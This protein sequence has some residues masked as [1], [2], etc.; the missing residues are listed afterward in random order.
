MNEFFIWLQT[1]QSTLPYFIGLGLLLCCYI[2]ALVLS[3]KEKMVLTAS[4]FDMALL[5]IAPVITVIGSLIYD[6]STDKT[7]GIVIL[8]V[9][10]V[11][12]LGSLIYSVVYNWTNYWGIFLSIMAKLFIFWLTAFITAILIALIFVYVI[13]SLASRNSEDGDTIILH[14][15][16]A[17]GAYVGYRV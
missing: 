10:G 13:I 4:K 16:K 11:M 3:K 1:N 17:I 8:S 12:F 6:E 9:A 7:I 2:A 5:L 15:D 14:Y